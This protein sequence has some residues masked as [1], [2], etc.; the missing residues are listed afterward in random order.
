M[1]KGRTKTFQVKEN[2]PTRSLVDYRV[3]W[4]ISRRNFAMKKFPKRASAR[5]DYTLNE[6]L[7]G[8]EGVNLS[9][10][11]NDVSTRHKYVWGVRS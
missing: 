3:E 10:Q 7:R 8:E 5:Q 2:S 4:S 1:E 6:S 9:K 11:D